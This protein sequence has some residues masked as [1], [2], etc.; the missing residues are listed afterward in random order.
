MTAAP[1]DPSPLVVRA[2]AWRPST[3]WA[4]EVRPAYDAL[5]GGATGDDAIRAWATIAMMMGDSRAPEL[6]LAVCLYAERAHGPSKRIAAH[7]DLCLLDLG[8]GATPMPGPVKLAALG[9]PGTVATP[10]GPLEAWIAR[11][12]IPFGGDHERAAMW[13]LRVAAHR[14]AIISVEPVP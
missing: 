13:A 8:L 5:I 6:A 3:G 11:A 2:A 12:L 14:L 9:E 10:I 7:R 1:I 4:S